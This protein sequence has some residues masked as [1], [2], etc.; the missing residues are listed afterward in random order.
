MATKKTETEKEKKGN[1]PAE[2]PEAKVKK[3]GEGDQP[4]KGFIPG[5]MK[6]IALP[7]I[8]AIISWVVITKVISPKLLAQKKDLEKKKTELKEEPPKEKPKDDMVGQIYTIENII[9]NPADSNGE[10]FVKTSIAL[11]MEQAKLAEE[12][13]KRDVQLRDILIG[14]FTSKTVEEITNPA[15]RESL[16][17][18]IKGKI[19]SLLVGEK[20]KNVYFTDL[21]IQ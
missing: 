20:I 14:I 5:R 3:G 11:E 15:K 13:T 2:V 16:R 17:Q 19:N 8:V 12:L 10:R 1:S 4:K 9:V 18:E 21:V 7:L 6:L